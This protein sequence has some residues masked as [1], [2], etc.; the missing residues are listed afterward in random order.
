MARLE[1]SKRPDVVVLGT[2]RC[3]T[4]FVA[5][6]LHEELGVH[7]AATNARGPRDEGL[8]YEDVDVRQANIDRIRFGGDGD[9]FYELDAYATDR[10][11]LQQLPWGL[12]CPRWAEFIDDALEVARPRRI[13][14]CTRNIPDTVRSWERVTTSDLRSAAEA[15]SRRHDALTG[16]LVGRDDVLRLDFTS[17]KTEEEI[18]EALRGHVR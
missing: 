1:G 16:A 4:S 15:V 11:H 8:V 13:V 9:W 17:R 7:M 12:K 3:G 14:W 5:G 6:L 2:G 18:L 10:V